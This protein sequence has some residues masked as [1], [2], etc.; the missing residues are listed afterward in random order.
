MVREFRSND[1][2]KTV[3]TKAGDEIGTVERISGDMAYVKPMQN[4]SNRVRQRLGWEDEED[5]YELK[6][7]K[8]TEFDDDEIHIRN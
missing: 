6:H 4:L 7:S 1:K 8:V 5:T 3:V 2:G